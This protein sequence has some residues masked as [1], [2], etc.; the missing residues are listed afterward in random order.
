MKRQTVFWFMQSTAG[1]HTDWLPFVREEKTPRR[2]ARAD[3]L[4]RINVS[5]GLTPWHP[6]LH[7]PSLSFK[8]SQKSNNCQIPTETNPVFNIP[9]SFL[10]GN[11]RN[12]CRYFCS[13][14]FNLLI[15]TRLWWVM[16]GCGLLGAQWPGIIWNEVS[17]HFPVTRAALS[18]SPGSHKPLGLV[19]SS[20]HSFSPRL[21]RWPLDSQ[22]QEN[23]RRRRGDLIEQENGEER[24]FLARMTSAM[25]AATGK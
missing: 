10:Y 8:S 16:G 2:E 6:S 20:S 12:I 3:C 19:V 18:V 13:V 22:R 11:E 7:C 5:A 21:C 9:K 24:S 25:S 15:M 4:P 1:C 17:G 23:M 14:W